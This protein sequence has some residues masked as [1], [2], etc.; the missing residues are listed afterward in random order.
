MQMPLAV[1]GLKAR[2]GRDADAELNFCRSALA[3]GAS[4]AMQGALE[5]ATRD[6]WMVEDAVDAVKSRLGDIDDVGGRDRFRARLAEVRS[7]LNDLRRRLDIPP[8]TI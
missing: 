4:L 6:V 1:S 3:R 5:A 8:A 2:A 7:G